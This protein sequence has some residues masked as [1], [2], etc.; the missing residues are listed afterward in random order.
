MDFPRL[1][2][3]Q[4]L[5]SAAVIA[6]GLAAMLYGA[7][8]HEYDDTL[9]A[10]AFF[11]GMACAACGVISIVARRLHKTLVALTVFVTLAGG[12]AGSA[13][14]ERGHAR[15]SSY[16]KGEPAESFAREK[17]AY[18]FWGLVL[19]A[20]IVPLAATVVAL[21]KKRPPQGAV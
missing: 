2:P 4:R 10:F 6:I 5:G 1:S 20:P 16:G 11:I 7:V 15:Q 13:L 3:K 14:W 18:F 9:T 12:I 17:R 21:V 19:G 8:E